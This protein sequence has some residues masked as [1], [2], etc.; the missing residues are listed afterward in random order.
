M[1]IRQNISLHY[2][3]IHVVYACIFQAVY[4]ANKFAKFAKRRERL[5]NWLDY[6]QLKFE[7]H[8]DRR[9]TVKVCNARNAN[10]TICDLKT[11]CLDPG[12]DIVIFLF[13]DWNFRALGWES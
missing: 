5:Q 9:P 6:Y 13:L 2:N 11:I 1:L 12:S 8:P 10:S 3:H 7:R 4:N